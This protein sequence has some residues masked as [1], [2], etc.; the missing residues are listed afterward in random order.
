ME[1]S[2]IQINFHHKNGN[3]FSFSF[4]NP[5]MIFS[6]FIFVFCFFLFG[7]MPCDRKFI[8]GSCGWPYPYIIQNFSAFVSINIFDF[9]EINKDW[10]LFDWAAVGARAMW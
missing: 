4:Y 1:P 10:P 6:W 5:K 8:L 9:D 2:N 7:V 3:S